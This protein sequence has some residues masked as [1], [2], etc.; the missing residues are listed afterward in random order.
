[1]TER[2]HMVC[3]VARPTWL[4]VL[5]LIAARIYE[6]PSWRSERSSRDMV[7]RHK[8]DSR[9][10]CRPSWKLALT[11]IIVANRLV[12]NRITSVLPVPGSYEKF[13]VGLERVMRS[14]GRVGGQPGIVILNGRCNRPDELGL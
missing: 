6:L 11:R 2:G 3:G 5:P 10:P 7:P 8:C 14:C 1:M 4:D 9:Y 13:L 12:L